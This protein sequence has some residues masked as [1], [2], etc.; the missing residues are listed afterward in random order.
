MFPVRIYLF[1]F[2][3]S[4]PIL[5]C[6]E[7]DVSLGAPSRLWN[8][9]PKTSDSMDDRFLIEDGKLDNIQFKDIKSKEV[10]DLL[11]LANQLSFDTLNFEVGL[12]LRAAEAIVLFR[13]GEDQIE[14]TLDDKIIPNLQTLDR[15]YYVGPIALQRLLTFSR[16]L[17]LSAIDSYRDFLLIVLDQLG[18]VNERAF[19]MLPEGDELS[20][21]PQD[22]LNPLTSAKVELGKLLFH[23]RG[24]AQNPKF[25]ENRGTY[26]C[27]SCHNAGAGFSSGNLQGFG[28]GGIGFGEYGEARKVDESIDPSLVD[29]QPV[30]TPPALN[31]N[32]QTVMLFDGKLGGVG[33]NLGTEFSWETGTPKA[34]N[35]LG[36][37]GVETQ[38]IAGLKAHRLLDDEY[39]ERT[40]QSL[41]QNP[42]YIQMFNEAFPP[43]SPVQGINQ[44]TAGLAIAAYERTLMSQEAPFQRLLRGDLYA[45]TEQELR[46]ALIFFGSAQCVSCHTG[47]ALNSMNFFPMGFGD[48]DQL[49]HD[50]E[51]IIKIENDQ[52]HL[53]RVSFTQ[54]DGDEFA[55]KVPQLY[56]LRDHAGYGHG[57]SFSTI[58]EVVDHMNNGLSANNR[59]ETSQTALRPQG[60]T[61][62]ECADL[63]AFIADALYDPNL[64]RFVP[65]QTP[66]GHCGINGDYQSL[67]DLEC[68]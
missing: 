45:L 40:E 50:G 17:K 68:D 60:M 4:L 19:F 32:W 39:P 41:G 13:A 28:E 55:F 18:G 37:Q 12:D 30:K 25:S 26:S 54:T 15:I 67:I 61:E 1:L 47:P 10:I 35:H 46:G 21:I 23:D 42:T 3:I 52:S 5:A 63:S 34:F 56:N 66:S 14:G 9:E 24:L 16:T 2:L 53:G 43:P 7:E 49:D 44:V 58:R 65:D 33:P 48:L 36:M 31:L 27:A 59:I 22:P 38:A 20:D 8:N 29:A 51:R 11:L 64:S 57:L 6:V 62:E